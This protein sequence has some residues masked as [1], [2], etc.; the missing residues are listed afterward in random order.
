[1]QEAEQVVREGPEGEKIPPASVGEH[2][3]HVIGNGVCRR[4]PGPCEQFPLRSVTRRTK[5]FVTSL[6][7]SKVTQSVKD[8]LKSRLDGLV[9]RATR[10]MK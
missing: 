4:S 10:E 2:T 3:L 5:E 7:A 1:M 6:A 9:H 8:E